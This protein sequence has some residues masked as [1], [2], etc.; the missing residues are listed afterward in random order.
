MIR[1]RGH[2]KHSNNATRGTPWKGSHDFVVAN[3]NECDLTE[4][5]QLSSR[6]GA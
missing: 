2:G 1:G 3:E 6:L 4:N 5:L